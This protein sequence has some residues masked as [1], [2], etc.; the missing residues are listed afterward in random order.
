MP[1]FILHCSSDVI[2]Q[3]HIEVILKEVYYTAARTKLFELN[4]I[5]V[6][7]QPFDHYD[8]GNER[9]NFIHV[10]AHIMEGRTTEQKADLSHRVV[11]K[12]KELFPSVPVISMNVAEF[13]KA[14][15][16]NLNSI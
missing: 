15:Y 10:F 14:T 16:N 6:R 7:I 11:S 1:H 13:E 2:T 12:L 5:K 8:V 9:K 4:D 3:V